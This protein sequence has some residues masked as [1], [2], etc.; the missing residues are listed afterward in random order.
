MQDF[1]GASSNDSITRAGE[2]IPAET[3]EN[4]NI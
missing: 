2:V 1:H 3:K 4:T